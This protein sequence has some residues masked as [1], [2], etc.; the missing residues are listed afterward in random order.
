MITVIKHAEQVATC[1]ICKSVLKYENQDV[2][3]ECSRGKYI[4]CP[5]CHAEVKSAFLDTT[6][7]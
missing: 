7:Y 3:Y 4:I 2:L 5:V 6:L 1:P